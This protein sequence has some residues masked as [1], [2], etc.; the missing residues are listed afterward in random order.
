MDGTTG[1]GG[2]ALHI[3]KTCPN[4]RLLIGID[5][6]EDNIEQTNQRLSPFKDKY[7]LVKGNFSEIKKIISHLKIEAV[8]GVILDL[9]VSSHQLLS[10]SRGFSFLV[11]GPLDMRTDR[12][13]KTTAGNVVN[14]F[15]KEE[16]K[17]IFWNYGEEKWSAA[18][19]QRIVKRRRET[20][21]TTTLE[22]A[23]LVTNAIPARAR[24]RKIHPATR[25][26]QALRIA[27]NDELTHLEKCLPEA[28]DVLTPGG[29][30]AVISF[31]SLEDRIV[32]TTFREHSRACICPP[33]IPQCRCGHI[34]KLK[35]LTK[36]PI[37]PTTEEISQNPR[38]RSARLRGAEKI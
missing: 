28:I 31:H 4:I 35:L 8:D 1:E 38:S 26:F 20:P 13:Q 18:I 29:R 10:P 2:H 7:F 27:V 5:R 3:L 12:Q 32:K 9:G 30:M 19:A 17:K 33:R 25:I 15:S 6:D 24:P 22:L 21:I 16:L 36:K 37:L 14:E 11:D 34:P 23:N